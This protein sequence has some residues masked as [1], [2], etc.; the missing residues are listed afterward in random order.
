MPGL[1]R[2][3]EE[4]IP[5]L[6]R[7]ARHLVRDADRA[8]DLVQE[9]LSRAL[10]NLDSW[11]PGT[12]LRAWLFVILK[13]CHIN[14]LRRAQRSPIGGEPT[15]SEPDVRSAGSQEARIALL[16]VRDALLG[17]SEEH[18]EVLLLVAIEELRYDEAAAILG[19]P[20]GTVRSRLSRAR[21]AL[22]AALENRQAT[23]GAGEGDRR[24]NNR[25]G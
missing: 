7:Y 12:N 18:R 5:R 1:L 3:I 17:L 21:R 15:L 24:E 11:T 2:T 16:E 8:D 4:E 9:S 20:L 19:V 6:R 14:E 22:R 25:S 13:N 23:G 10:G